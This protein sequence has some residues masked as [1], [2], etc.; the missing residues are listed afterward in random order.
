MID[1]AQMLIKHEG[2]R[3]FVYRCPA[4]K[5][6]IGV[7]RNLEDRGITNAEAMYLLHNDIEN[8][9]QQLKDRFYWFENIHEDAQAV[10]T[11]MCFNM[12]LGGLLTFQATLEHLKN[13]NYKAASV[14]MLES[15][16]KTQVGVRALEL[17]DILKNI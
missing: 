11:D 9:I 15:K 16:W 5:L 12:G 7:G 3:N 13:E 6:T 4:G 1:I 8:V 17:S 2:L 10:M 14:T